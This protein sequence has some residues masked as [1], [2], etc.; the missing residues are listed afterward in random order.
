MA[1]RKKKPAPDFHKLLARGT[2]ALHQGKIDEA[3]KLLEQAHQLNQTD[4]NATLNLA[5]V[6]ILSKRFQRAVELL[7]PLTKIEPDNPMVWTNL[8]AAYLGN[9]VLASKE[10]Q[11][12]A[13]TSFEKALEIDPQVPNVAYNLG[14]IYRDRQEYSQA[15]RWFRRAL[16]TNPNDKDARHYIEL[17]SKDSN[18]HS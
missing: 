14:L 15:I 18:G 8:G 1:K 10:N 9:P 13:I 7:K 11:Q 5:G 3:R 16:E 12:K 2:A 6:Y 17:L 4:G